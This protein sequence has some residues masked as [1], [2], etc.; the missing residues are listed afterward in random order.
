MDVSLPS[1]QVSEHRATSTVPTHKKLLVLLTT[2]TPREIV[3]HQLDFREIRGRERD[4][5]LLNELTN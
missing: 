2:F 5:H 3:L 1:A 4:T